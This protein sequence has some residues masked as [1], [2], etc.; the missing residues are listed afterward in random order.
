LA[1]KLRVVTHQFCKITSSI[2][3]VFTSVLDS[4]GPTS[5]VNY[6][7]P[8]LNSA[9]FSI[10]P[11]CYYAITKHSLSICG[12]FWRW[13]HVLYIKTGSPSKLC[14]RFR[15][16]VFLPMLIHLFMALHVSD[17][18]MCCLMHVR[19]QLKCDGTWWRTGGEVKGK[20]A[21]RVGSQYS[22]RYVGTWCI[23][24]YYRLCARLGCQ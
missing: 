1:D 14:H 4:A 11:L 19:V 12:E 5:V 2:S 13:K 10:M 23:Q 24:H 21:N 16:P 15:F 3:A 17:V 20:L 7:R 22:S 18:R 8:G 9:Q 6:G